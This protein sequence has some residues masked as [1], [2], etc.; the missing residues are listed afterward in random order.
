MCFKVGI[1]YGVFRRDRFNATRQYYLLFDMGSAATTC[2]VMAF[3]TV[4]NND[5]GFMETVPQLSVL[6]VGFAC[7]CCLLIP[8]ITH[9]C[10][11][12]SE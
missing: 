1:N 6:G 8:C 11:R 9:V 4:K 5:N 3:E 10:V 7:L 12:V 2:T